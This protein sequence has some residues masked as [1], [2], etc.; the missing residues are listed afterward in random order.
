MLTLIW[1]WITGFAWEDAQ[2]ELRLYFASHYRLLLWLALGS[3]LFAALIAAICIWVPPLP[4][5]P[6]PTLVIL[7]Q[8]HYPQTFSYELP[9]FV[10]GVAI[11]AL[12]P[13]TAK[14]PPDVNRL[15]LHPRKVF[16]VLLCLPLAVGL[17]FAL[18]YDLGPFEILMPNGLLSLAAIL[19]PVSLLTSY[20][21]RIDSRREFWALASMW[22]ASQT[23]ILTVADDIEPP[24]SGYVSASAINVIVLLT[25][26]V[27]ALGVA[28]ILAHRTRKPAF[29][30]GCTFGVIGHIGQWP[31]A[32]V[33]DRLLGI[34]WASGLLWAMRWFAAGTA[35]IHPNNY[36]YIVDL[37][38]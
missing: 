9:L 4:A 10:A 14:Y 32:I 15:A 26:P 18:N 3:I 6:N 5:L 33:L 35:Y 11:I 23:L 37:I 34:D 25:W 38:K 13:P 12:L 17:H 24:I 8:D 19:V 22:L 1:P 16:G 31:T 2:R 29:V 20:L 27:F 7:Q 30:I 36:Y 21:S 28:L